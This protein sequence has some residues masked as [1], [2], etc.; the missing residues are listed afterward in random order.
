MT[1]NIFRLFLSYLTTVESLAQQA[2]IRD[3]SGLQI[4]QINVVLRL[5]RIVGNVGIWNFVQ[6]GGCVFM[7]VKFNKKYYI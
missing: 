1:K 2:K 3:V 7:F 5:L 6:Y 4:M